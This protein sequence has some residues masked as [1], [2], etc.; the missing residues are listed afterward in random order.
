MGQQ[1]GGVQFHLDFR[2]VLFGHLKKLEKGRPFALLQIGDGFYEISVNYSSLEIRINE[3]NDD[4]AL[5]N[6]VCLS[7]E[8]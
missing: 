8:G 3:S 1:N 2:V 6:R 5:V 7:Q 4:L